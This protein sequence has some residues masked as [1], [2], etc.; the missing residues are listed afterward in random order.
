MVRRTLRSVRLLSAALGFVAPILFGPSVLG[1]D[2]GITIP[3]DDMSPFTV[4]LDGATFDPAKPDV[5][6]ARA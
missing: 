2:S 4:K 6:V 1:A 3:G 5:E